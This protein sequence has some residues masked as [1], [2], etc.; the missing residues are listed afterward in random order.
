MRPPSPQCVPVGIF[1]W[2]YRKSVKA[3]FPAAKRESRSVFFPDL[4]A[5]S[6]SGLP[7]MYWLWNLLKSAFVLRLKFRNNSSVSCPSKNTFCSNA[8]R[9]FKYTSN[10]NEALG[11]IATGRIYGLNLSTA[12]ASTRHTS[13]NASAVCHASYGLNLSAL[14]SFCGGQS[15]RQRNLRKR[16]NNLAM[17]MVAFNL[18]LLFVFQLAAFQ[19]FFGDRENL[20]HR[21]FEFLGRFLFGRGWHEARYMHSYFAQS[22]PVLMLLCR[23]RN[24]FWRRFVDNLFIG[25]VAKKAIQG[26]CQWSADR[27][28]LRTRN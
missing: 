26:E 14:F 15:F 18:A 9:H 8:R 12:S 22:V 17:P 24:Y 10:A 16:P 2:A 25:R 7:A 5:F 4:R 27:Y 23:F 13:S 11:T 6:N 21:F 28:G 3:F 1:S 20:F 19:F